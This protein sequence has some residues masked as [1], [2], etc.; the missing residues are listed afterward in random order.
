M[1]SFSSPLVGVIAV[2][3]I[4]LVTDIVGELLSVMAALYFFIIY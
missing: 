2:I 3:V 1:H 4:V